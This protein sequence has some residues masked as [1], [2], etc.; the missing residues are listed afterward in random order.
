MGVKGWVR[1]GLLLSLIER[2]EISSEG[3][4]LMVLETEDWRFLGL[5]LRGNWW[6]PRLDLMAL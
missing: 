2:N 1:R 5:V 3:F 4:I 6:V